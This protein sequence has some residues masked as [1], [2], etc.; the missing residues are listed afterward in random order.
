MKLD[1][2]T[3][4][5]YSD[6]EFDINGN[7]LRAKELGLDGIAITDHDNIDSWSEIDHNQYPIMVIKGVE[8]S[9]YHKGDSIHILGYYLNNGE[10]YQE[11]A[12]TLIE[13]REDRLERLEKI[14]SKLKDLGIELTKEEIMKEADGAVGRPH[15][16][17]AIMKKYPELHLSID[18][19]F[20]RYIGNQDPAYVP[21]NNYQTEDAIKMLKRNNCLVVLAHPLEIKK[22]DYH[23]IIDLGIDG[24]E[25]F[26]LYKFEPQDD[27]VSLGDERNLLVTGGSDYHG[28]N[29]RDAMGKVYLEGDRAKVFLKRIH[30]E[31]N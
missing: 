1:L 7:V 14:I 11:L 27:I 21:T 15:V 4:T 22:I 25:G 16:A 8:L 24:I 10:S 5:T 20:D 17:K 26:Y 13:F 23:E 12:S 30:K 28:S 31:N 3:H 29:A 2:H 9:T 19:V 18:D 6:G